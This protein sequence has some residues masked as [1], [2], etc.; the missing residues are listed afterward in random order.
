MDFDIKTFVMGCL[1]GLALGLGIADLVDKDLSTAATSLGALMAGFGA[2]GTMYI[3]YTAL[4]NWKTKSDFDKLIE[5]TRSIRKHILIL[6]EEITANTPL[7]KPSSGAQIGKTMK[8]LFCLKDHQVAIIESLE[9]IKTILEIHRVSSINVDLYLKLT[10]DITKPIPKAT[11]LFSIDQ[12]PLA[13]KGEV[14]QLGELLLPLEGKIRKA[15]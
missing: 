1:V 2:L 4:S 14:L 11:H 9:S 13:S 6:I 5:E 8:F 10:K 15:F 7:S 3:A 12:L